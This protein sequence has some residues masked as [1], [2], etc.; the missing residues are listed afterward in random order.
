MKAYFALLV[1]LVSGC[2]AIHRSYP[3]DPRIR[4]LL[5]IEDLKQSLNRR[6]S[7]DPRD[8]LQHALEVLPAGGND[9]AEGEIRQ[10]LAQLPRSG[11]DFV[12][13]RDFVLHR[14]RRKLDQAKDA[15]L[16]EPSRAIEPQPCDAAPFVIDLTRDP[17]PRGVIELYGY[18]FDRVP[19]EMVQVHSGSFTDVTFALTMRDRSHLTLKLGD[20]GVRFFPESEMLGLVWGHLI[21][22]TIPIIHPFTSLCA[23]QVERIPAGLTVR[24]SPPR[25]GTTSDA[26]NSDATIRANVTLESVSNALNVLLCATLA[27]HHGMGTAFSGCAAEQIFTTDT[28]QHIEQIFGGTESD[29]SFTHRLSRSPI[30]RRG[31]P[32]GPVAQWTFA[33]MDSS[34]VT[35]VAP[36]LAVQLNEIRFVS[37]PAGGCVSPIAYLEAK[38]RNLLSPQTIQ[39]LEPQLQMVD[40][41]VRGRS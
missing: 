4:A 28:D 20:N 29:V 3:S 14:V 33:T 1:L 36:E 30:V 21:H 15:L 32:R 39:R 24:F 38:R 5:S 41:A 40:P 13:G 37:T 12:C 18:D 26:M 27:T 34:D 22:Y 35:S 25:T 31:D 11:D 19:L 16:N 9:L 8:I 2:A 7:A 10:F 17:E 23:S 6:R